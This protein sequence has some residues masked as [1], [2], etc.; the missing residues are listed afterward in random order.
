MPCV[1]GSIHNDPGHLSCITK[2][3]LLTHMRHVQEIGA[4]R[5]GDNEEVHHPSNGEICL[6]KTPEFGYI[7][8]KCLQNNFNSQDIL[9]Y[10]IDYGNVIHVAAQTIRVSGNNY[11][12]Y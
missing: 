8:I 10:S 6:A 7:R 9:V 5:E 11:N 2:D 1:L 4:Y 12:L 3:D